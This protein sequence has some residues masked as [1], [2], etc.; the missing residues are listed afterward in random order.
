LAKRSRNTLIIIAIAA[1]LAAY[2]FLVEQPRHRQ[3]RER[4]R[5]ATELA[6][7][8][9][10]EATYVEIDRPDVT[11]VFVKR[12]A[13]WWLTSP[14][15]DRAED[16]S[17]MRLLAILDSG[18]I[19]RDLG[20]L[21]Q[22]TD[23]AP[24]G[25]SEPAASIT[26]VAAG[27]TVVAL[28]VGKLNVEKTHAYARRRGPPAGGSV[29]LIPTAVRRYSL[30]EPSGYRSQRLVEFDLASV[31]SFAVRW[32]SHS[33][34]CRR[35]PEAGGWEISSNGRAFPGSKRRVE[36]ILRR[37]RGLRVQQFVPATEVP[38]VKP[39]DPLTG[40]VVVALDDG[41]ESVVT[42]GRRLEGLVY[43]G[44]GAG[45]RVVL[46]D[47]T[48]VVIFEATAIVLR[49]RRLLR[50]ERG[51]ITK[52]TVESDSVRVTLVRPGDEWAYP[53]PSMGRID[54]R[55]VGRALTAISDL[56]YT[57]VVDENP[58]AR[59]SYGLSKPDLRLTIF[60]ADGAPLDWLDCKRR[61]SPPA[62]YVVT[63]RSAGVI[64]ELEGDALDA[65]VD[66]FRSLRDP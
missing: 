22:Q 28:D 49:D 50:F 16:G 44:A 21:G 23:F 43:V 35:N 65:V 36:E 14:L 59:R 47:T 57:V 64:A 55:K 11:L 29:I 7:F 45:G 3:E 46:A 48:V 52:V 18:E 6:A 25:L 27:D 12:D 53:N 32:P 10:V 41:S 60:G 5:A 33:L 9:P 13:R 40:S 51:N 8:D 26:V 38:V 17:I 42:V 30:G 1:V 66:L 63:S 4:A 62:V 54:Q 24:Y 34:V 56:E 39:F 61:G 31:A 20:D 19:A 37:L 2:F 58:D 15:Q